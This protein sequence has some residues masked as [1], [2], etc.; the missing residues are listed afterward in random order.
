M[1]FP[2]GCNEGIQACALIDPTVVFTDGDQNLARAIQEIWPQATHLLCRFHIAQNITRALAGTFRSRLNQ[3]LDD[4]WRVASLESVEE[5]ESEFRSM[6]VKWEQGC[7][8]L[9]VLERKKEKWAF[10]Y[11]HDHFVA[12]IA[13]T[14]RQESI[15][16]QIKESLLSN[17]SLARIID[18]FASVEKRTAT[19]MIQASITTKLSTLTEDPMINDAV[20]LLTSYAGALLKQEC[21]LSLSYTCKLRN[22][23]DHP[24]FEI[25]HKDFPD[26]SRTVTFIPNEIQKTFCSCRKTVWHGIVCRHILCTFRHV[27]QMS[28]PIQMFNSRWRKDYAS[29][30]RHHLAVQIAM[31]STQSPAE[32]IPGDSVDFRIDDLSAAAKSIISKAAPSESTYNLVKSS[33]VVLDEMVSTAITSASHDNDEDDIQIRNPIKARTKGR[34]KTGAKRYKSQAELQ[35]RKH[36]K[37]RT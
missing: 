19:K 6:M 32:R 7:D 13:S 18:G 37:N 30:N 2:L 14:Q 4:F 3:F 23:L 21:V 8:Y 15:N 26:K 31:G 12:G 27:N 1:N 28:C 17:S 22:N 33:L 24:T 5:F 25:S 10:A 36:K 35:R 11:T 34:P 16:A 20:Q 9:E 29:K